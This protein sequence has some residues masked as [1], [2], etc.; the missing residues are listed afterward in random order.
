MENLDHLKK[1]LYKL[2]DSLYTIHKSTLKRTDTK[3][4][5][6]QLK[7]PTFP[8]VHSEIDFHFQSLRTREVILEL[9]QEIEGCF[10]LLLERWS[11]KLIQ[12]QDSKSNID[13]LNDSKGLRSF[14]S[15]GSILPSVSIDSKTIYIRDSSLC[16]EWPRDL[17]H[18]K[19]KTFPKENYSIQGPGYNLEVR[20]QY[21]LENI[22]PS[23]C[24][25]A[26]GGRPRLFSADSG[27]DF[28]VH[29]PHERKNSNLDKSKFLGMLAS[30][31]IYEES[32]VGI[33]LISSEVYEGS[34]IE[35]EDFGRSS[36]DLEIEMKDDTPEEGKVSLFMLNCDR[37]R[38]LHLFQD[39]EIDIN[40]L[41]KMGLD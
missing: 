8:H 34:S 35:G 41:L 26:F 30:Q 10:P 22:R 16:T 4:S 3:D 13:Y 15:A 36:F 14:L 37:I 31:N 19:L 29:Q 23:I 7:P 33:K 5:Y 17:K 11:F 24:I 21:Y 32:E 2:C 38:E 39:L 9:V 25:Q 18:N 12:T 1:F 27:P 6:F 40:E 28:G 20:I